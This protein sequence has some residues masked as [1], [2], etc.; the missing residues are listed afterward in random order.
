MRKKAG[1]EAK[2]V[3]VTLRC[4]YSGRDGSSG[5]GETIEIDAAEAERLVSL[6]VAEIVGAG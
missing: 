3:R 6:G 1:A 5:P 4:V 2:P